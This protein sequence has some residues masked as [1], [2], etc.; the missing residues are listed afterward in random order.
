M[1]TSIE[2]PNS[3]LTLFTT[4]KKTMPP[5]DPCCYHQMLDIKANIH[6]R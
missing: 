5:Q 2:A 1:Q 3:Y 4:D 6:K